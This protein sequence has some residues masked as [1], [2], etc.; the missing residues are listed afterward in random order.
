MYEA[1]RH[2]P[3]DNNLDFWRKLVEVFFDENAKFRIDFW[4][5]RTQQHK[6]FDLSVRVL[7]RYLKLKYETGLK[8]VLEAALLC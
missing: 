3:S 7:P 2:R 4:S 5:N 8:E 1:Q 6:S